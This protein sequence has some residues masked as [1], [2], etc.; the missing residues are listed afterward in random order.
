M[1]FKL[2][3]KIFIGLKLIKEARESGRRRNKRT[4]RF[5]KSIKWTRY[6]DTKTGRF[7]KSMVWRFSVGF[8]F[9]VKQ[10][11]QLE[12]PIRGKYYGSLIQLWVVKLD[13][14][15][16]Q[17]AI[18]RLKELTKNSIAREAK[19]KAYGKEC[20]INY[21]YGHGWQ[22]VPVEENKEMLDKW[23]YRFEDEDGET[24]DTDNGDVKNL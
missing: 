12:I 17:P 6:R 22:Q 10:E 4:G 9:N 15:L 1:I 3:S 7:I 11:L 2:L 19:S 20:I 13:G 14:Y 16:E 8:N 18:D 23:E 5:A 24:I 21:D